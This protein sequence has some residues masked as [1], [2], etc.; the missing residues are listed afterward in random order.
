MAENLGDLVTERRRPELAELDLMDTGEL[1][2]LMALEEARVPEAVARQTPQIA[3]AVDAVADRL[4]SGGR[5]VYVGAGTAG[6]M[7][8]LDAVE[9]GPTFGVGPDRVVGVLAGG[10]EAMFGPRES[11][12]DSAETGSSDLARLDV[13]P[14]DAVV[15]VSASGRTP[16]TL[17]AVRYARERGA[18]TVGLSCNPGA[19]L[20]GLV[21]H[22]IEVVVG[23]EI[24]AGS[25][26]LK[27]GTAQK[28]VLNMI[29]TISMVRLGKTY[30]NLMVDVRASNV[31]LRERARRIVELAT[32]AEP[33][34][35]AA[36]LDRCG[37]EARVAIVALL[38]DVGPDE[39]RRRLAAGSV[40]DALRGEG[41][42]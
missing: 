7:G 5:L 20:S 39:A 3:A 33:E 8:V 17:G 36:A 37:G 4:R 10:R 6:R 27:A 9:C 2:R 25:T 28:L 18:L 34:E 22:P 21:D 24:L 41:A 11:A 35:A 1:V 13:G 26:R 19:R 12:E 32:S 38:L 16:Y 30:G 29:S 23:P 31:K 42:T 15:G 40:R 14:E